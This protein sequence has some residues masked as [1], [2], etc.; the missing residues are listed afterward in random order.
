MGLNIQYT[1]EAEET[2][3]S[4]YYFIIEKF[5]KR[6]AEAFLTKADKIIQLIAEMPEMYKAAPFDENVRIGL[7][8]KQTSI[9]YR[10]KED[11]VELLFF[12][13]NRQEPIL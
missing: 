4:V 2:L 10:M 12:W 7:I 6:P 8:S 11:S 1:P 13:D 5:G 9:F 3:N